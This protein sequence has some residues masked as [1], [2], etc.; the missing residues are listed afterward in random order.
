[1]G[2]DDRRRDGDLVKTSDEHT[3]DRRTGEELRSAYFS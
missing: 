3:C 1:M 2:N